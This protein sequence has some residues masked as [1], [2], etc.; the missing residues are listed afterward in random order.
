MDIKWLKGEKRKE[1]ER[2][3]ENESVH[4]SRA[5]NLYFK[6]VCVCVCMLGLF[7]LGGLALSY[8]EGSPLVAM[9][10]Q[11]SLCILPPHLSKIPPV[12]MTTTHGSPQRQRTSCDL[13]PQTSCQCVCV[14]VCVFS[15]FGLYGVDRS[16]VV[17]GD[18]T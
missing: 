8:E 13:C 2:E 10:Q 9:A 15:L 14:C 12:T 5:V 17:G 4:I 11:L 18:V 3:R 16:Y 1:R 6:C 7:T